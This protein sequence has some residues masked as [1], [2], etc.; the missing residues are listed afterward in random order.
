MSDRAKVTVVTTPEVPT[1]V[2]EKTFGTVWGPIVRSRGLGGN[3]VAGLRSLGGEEIKEYTQM[4][5]QSR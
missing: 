5:G 2:I 3:M 4:L 1:M